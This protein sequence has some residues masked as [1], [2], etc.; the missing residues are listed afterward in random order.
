[1]ERLD[2]EQARHDALNDPK[3]I[4]W[5]ERTNM[6]EPDLPTEEWLNREAIC[7]CGA[8]S[9]SSDTLPFFEFRGEGSKTATNRCRNCS[10]YVSAHDDKAAGLTAN[11][12]ICS[13]F[14]PSGPWR[15]DSFYCGH[16]GWD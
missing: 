2:L 6:P 16:A 11:K 14:V 3:A 8:L 7:T 4:A 5:V 1:M 12:F 15:Y 10:Y 13:H 9:P